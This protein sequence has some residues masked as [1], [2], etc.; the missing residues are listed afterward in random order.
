MASASNG[1]SETTAKTMKWAFRNMLN[2]QIQK[3]ESTVTMILSHD[4][5]VRL[6][7]VILDE[8][9]DQRGHKQ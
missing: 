1:F 8:D 4:F 3:N 6:A 5:A 7:E 2:E 9:G